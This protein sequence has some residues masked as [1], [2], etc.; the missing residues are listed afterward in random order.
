VPELVIRRI[1][2]NEGSAYRDVRL[3]AL[4][5]APSAFGTTLAQ[6]SARPLAW[7][8]SRAAVT[9]ESERSALFVAESGDH[10]S[11]L[12]GAEM[13]DDVPEAEVIS[14]WV[15][16]P[17]RS[18]GVGRQLLDAAAAWALARGAVGLQ[19]WVTEGNVPATALYEAYG[20]A[21]TG[22]TQP[23]PSQPGLRELHMRRTRH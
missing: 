5:D 12:I 4:A 11:G 14:M 23:H 18:Q 19:L 8:E 1:R 9:A 2:A 16:P 20:F 17:L 21:F 13:L 15:E 10:V 3:R 22:D 6:A 7:W